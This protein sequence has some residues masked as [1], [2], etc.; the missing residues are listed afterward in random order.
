MSEAVQN[1]KSKTKPENLDFL[2]GERLRGIIDV[3]G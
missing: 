2:S 1:A 3:E